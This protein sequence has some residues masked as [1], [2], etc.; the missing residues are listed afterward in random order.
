M[1]TYTLTQYTGPT[2]NDRRVVSIPF[3]STPEWLDLMR[4]PAVEVS[5]IFHSEGKADLYAN[6]VLHSS[7]DISECDQTDIYSQRPG[8]RGILEY[9]GTARRRMTIMSQKAAA[10]PND[11]IEKVATQARREASH[12]DSKEVIASKMLSVGEGEVESGRK[13]KISKDSKK[14]MSKGGAVK[15][16]KKMRCRY[17]K[18]VDIPFDACIGDLMLF[19]KGLDV[20]QMYA[21]KASTEGKIS[22]YVACDSP[23][24]AGLALKRSGESIVYGKLKHKQDPS[25]SDKNGNASK[26]P[27]R[28]E[29]ALPAEATWAKAVGAQ[30]DGKGDTARVGQMWEASVSHF[31][32]LWNN[33]P[34]TLNSKGEV[35]SDESLGV[36]R[37]VRESPASLTACCISKGITLPQPDTIYHGARDGMS[38]GGRVEQVSYNGTFENRAVVSMLP[39]PF[40][41]IDESLEDE[42]DP[43]AFKGSK[44]QGAILGGHYYLEKLRLLRMA[45][46]WSGPAHGEPLS[47]SP[48]KDEGIAER[49][50]LLYG[51]LSA[52]RFKTLAPDE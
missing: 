52:M 39:S 15:R 44:V 22:V 35:T 41:Y 13:R 10:L 46:A 14:V 26:I 33:H 29:Q 17:V 36:L 43:G 37:V 23:E 19:L 28:V 7:I 11:Q 21:C 2:G 45:E 9:R 50:G 48:P 49:L 27:V 25:S 42:V 24:V 1:E 4:D 20:A 3:K 8:N 30:L 34:V 6:D 40:Q 31:I 51:R 32:D 5:L 18:L 12:L 38:G 47:P 16:K